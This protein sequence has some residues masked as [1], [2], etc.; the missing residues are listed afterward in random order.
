MFGTN[1]N[2]NLVIETNNTP[3]LIIFTTS[4]V[5]I[6][7]TS[8]PTYKLQ[9]IGT[10][11]NGPLNVNNNLVVDING[12]VGIVKK[13]PALYINVNGD[14]NIPDGNIIR[15][16]GAAMISGDATNLS[17]GMYLLLEI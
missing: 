12:N 17:V 14:I 5:S 11:T 13:E 16:F 1:D 15:H 9:I 7:V 3:A 10:A 8:S 2:Y 4:N 6:G